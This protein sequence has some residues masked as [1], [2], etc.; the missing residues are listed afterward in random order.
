MRLHLILISVASLFLLSGCD[1][2]KKALF[3]NPAIVDVGEYDGC[4]VKYVNRGWD[5][6]SF[7]IFFFYYTV[8]FEIFTKRGSSSIYKLYGF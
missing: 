3:A 1:E 7:Y 4:S 6:Q 8:I 2:E 5:L